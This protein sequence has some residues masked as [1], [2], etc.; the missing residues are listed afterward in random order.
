MGELSGH[1]GYRPNAGICL[2]NSQGNV[3]LGR[4]LSAGPEVAEPGRDWQMPQGGIEP[5][6]RVI[7]TALRELNEET[8][9]RSASLLAITGNWWRYDFPTGYVPTG[10]KLDPFKGQV[11]K[12]I[13]FRFSGDDSEFDLSSESCSEP[14]EFV[15][16]KWMTPTQTLKC[17]VRFKEQQYRRVFYAFRDLLP[18]WTPELAPNQ[19]LSGSPAL[20]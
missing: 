20:T 6:E 8:G 14:Q 10:H 1:S 18:G 17:C 15:E 3:W 2:I 13:A 4:T 16:W 5:G 7:T 9:A 12:W 19:E 11:Q